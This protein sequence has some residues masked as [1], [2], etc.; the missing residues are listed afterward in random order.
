MTSALKRLLSQAS[1]S[2][3]H[4]I[5]IILLLCLFVQVTFGTTRT[6]SNSDSISTI[7][8]AVNATD[9]DDTL[10][11]NG[12]TYS[13]G[14]TLYRLY[15][16]NKRCTAGHELIVKNGTGTPI[17]DFTGHPIDLH[18]FNGAVTVSG[19][20]VTWSSGDKFVTPYTGYTWAGT[21]IQINGTD[22][23]VDT[24]TNDTHLSVTGCSPSSGT[25]IMSAGACGFIAGNSN[26]GDC[27]RGAWGVTNSSY[28]VFDG[29]EIKGVT[30]TESD[31][32]S[33]IRL[34]GDALAAPGNNDHVTIKNCILQLNYQGIQFS[35]GYNTNQ[36][37]E[38]TQFLANGN[39]SNEQEHQLYDGGGDYNFI[40]YSYFNETGCCIHVDGSS[41]QP[42]DSGGQNLHSRSFHVYVY[43][44]WFQDAYQYEFDQ[45]AGN[46]DYD[47]GDH[48]QQMFFYGNVVVPSTAPRNGNVKVSTWLVDSPTRYG[49]VNTSGTGGT[50]VTWVSGD[51]FTAIFGTYVGDPIDIGAATTCTIATVTDATHLTVSGCTP[52]AGSGT[53]FTLYDDWL[54]GHGKFY[55]EAKWNTFYSPNPNGQ[56]FNASTGVGSYAPNTSDQF[57]YFQLNN[58]GTFRTDYGGESRR[59]EEINLY[60]ANN[61]FYMHDGTGAGHNESLMLISIGANPPC[62]DCAPLSVPSAWTFTG[63]HNSF[64][65]VMINNLSSPQTFTDANGTGSLTSGQTYSTSSPPFTDLGS[66]NFIP[67]SA[68]AF[69]TADESE[70]LP[71]PLDFVQTSPMVFVAK[72]SFTD[73]GALSAADAPTVTSCDSLSP[74]SATIS[75]LGTQVYAGVCTFSDSSTGA[76]P[77]LI[78]GST[79]HAVATVSSQTATG[80]APGSSTISATDNGHACGNTSAL[81]VSAATGGSS[82][83]PGVKLTSGTSLK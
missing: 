54:A 82:M 3:L 36:V 80:V 26:A 83:T 34:T 66:L 20:A 41:N 38:Y 74:S 18:L 42:G 78:L 24:Y 70:T 61:V 5:G 45:M 19:S 8:T 58:F 12:G 27:D 1:M 81:T 75:I 35:G 65:T 46:P 25:Y 9:C 21:F 33:A 43:G 62:S 55:F 71:Y 2:F 6:V 17:F 16:I 44:N 39:P 10:Q 31:N 23:T 7:Q 68:G 67:D 63:S 13:Y 50:S 4:G 14:A 22:C 77:E 32:S 69:G 73:R 60:L 29:I 51:Q 79:D 52:G 28:I 59:V 56:S 64:D 72:S 76:C 40:R 15:I 11:F 47:P 37:I 30:S 57:S 53:A 49:T 48:T